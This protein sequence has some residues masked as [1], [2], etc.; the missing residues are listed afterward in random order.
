[1]TATQ[2][3]LHAGDAGHIIACRCRSQPSAFTEALCASI[4]TQMQ[5]LFLCRLPVLTSVLCVPPAG[6]SP[7]VRAMT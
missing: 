5:L 1:M 2:A 4:R 7:H 3:S 6:A